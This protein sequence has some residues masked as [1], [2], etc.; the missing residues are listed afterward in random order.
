MHVAEKEKVLYSK[1]EILNKITILSGGRAAEQ[2]EF[3]SITT[4][5]SNDIERASQIARSMVTQYGMTERFGFVNWE[6]KNSLYLLSNTTTNCSDSTAAQIDE[7]IQTITK[8]CYDRAVEILATH[9]ETLDKL[10][11]VL[12]EKENITGEQF[13]ELLREHEPDIA[14]EIDKKTAEKKAEGGQP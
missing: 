11:A 5:A 6:K 2:V 8:S 1:E 9:R 13:M 12:F 3:S 10:A 7:E 4:G 14:A